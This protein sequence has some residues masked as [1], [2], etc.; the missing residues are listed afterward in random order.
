MDLQLDGLGERIRRRGGRFQLLLQFLGGH[1][2]DAWC[3][4]QPT[5]QVAK[6]FPELS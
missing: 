1:L 5:L 4:L 6:L 3:G 2:A